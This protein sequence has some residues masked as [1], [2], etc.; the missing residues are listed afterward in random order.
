MQV[1][2]ELHLH[3]PVGELLHP[4]PQEGAQVAHKPSG[5]CRAMWKGQL[6]SAPLEHAEDFQKSSWETGIW[7]EAH[8][9]SLTWDQPWLLIPREQQ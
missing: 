5:A 4:H 8:S 7:D 1:G 3:L 9:L 2:K 6:R